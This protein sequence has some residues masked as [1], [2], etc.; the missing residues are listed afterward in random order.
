M[1]RTLRFI[2]AAS[3]LALS[4]NACGDDTDETMDPP[5]SP[6][7]SVTQGSSVPG[8]EETDSCYDP[9]N[10]TVEAGTEVTWN[11]DDSAAHTVTSGTPQDGPDGTFDSSLFMAGNS[12][13]HVFD[14]PG[15]YPYF[16]MVHPWMDGTV[17]VE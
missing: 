13:D 8:C 1:N 11:N 17:T 2:C 7:V 10:L 5:V 4:T 6:T 14:T 12:F 15:T 16:C 9:A 3:L